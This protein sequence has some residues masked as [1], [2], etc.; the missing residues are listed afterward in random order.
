MK[1]MINI[2]SIFHAIKISAERKFQNLFSI[3]KNMIT[4]NQTINKE[5]KRKNAL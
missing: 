1:K 3:L 2:K 4:F 5:I